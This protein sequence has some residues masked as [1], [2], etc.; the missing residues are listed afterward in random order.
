[1]PRPRDQSLSRRNGGDGL[2]WLMPAGMALW[3]IGLGMA[4]FAYAANLEEKD[5]FA[6]YAMPNG[7]P[8]LMLVLVPQLRL[9][10][11]SGIPPNRRVAWI[12]IQVSDLI[13]AH[14]GGPLERG[15]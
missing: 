5:A 14:K 1:M 15:T 8:L 7:K 11:H 6:P 9:T 2:D 4:G 13:G 12:F 10:W 3:V